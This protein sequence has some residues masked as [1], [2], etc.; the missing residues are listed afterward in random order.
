MRRSAK[1][2]PIPVA[3]ERPST[4]TFRGK[5]FTKRHILALA[6]EARPALNK[7]VVISAVNTGVF[8]IEELKQHEKTM[9]EELLKTWR[10]D[11]E[12]AQALR[13]PAMV[14]ADREENEIFR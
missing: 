13:G 1:A 11:V 2:I 9:S 8:T 3:S 6:S 7:A 5:V 4:L 12:V 14:V 10:L